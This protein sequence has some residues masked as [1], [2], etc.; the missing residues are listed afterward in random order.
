MAQALKAADVVMISGGSSVGIKD[1]TVDVI[2]GFPRSEVF[3]HG[4]SIAPGKPTIFARAAGKPV[5]GLPGHPV[6]ALVVFALFGAP[7]IRM[8]ASTRFTTAPVTPRAPTKPTARSIGAK[9][10]KLCHRRARFCCWGTARAGPMRLTTGWPTS[11]STA[12]M[13]PPK[14]SQTCASTSIIWTTRRCYGWPNTTSVVRRCETSGTVVGANQAQGNRQFT[15]VPSL[16]SSS[17]WA[18]TD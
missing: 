8:V 10:L 13:S 16:S 12:R 1:M 3:F 15:R 9:S 2:C 6:S 18:A 4:I 17:R 14:W 5:M 11:S 7:L